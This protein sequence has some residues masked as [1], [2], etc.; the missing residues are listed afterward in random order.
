MTAM[1]GR[2]LEDV[3]HPGVVVGEALEQR[4]QLHPGDAVAPQADEVLLDRQVG[5]DRPEAEQPAATA[6]GDEPVDA[7]DVL[8]GVGDAEQHPRST[9]ASLEHARQRGDLAVAHP[10]QLRN[11]RPQ[12]ALGDR[13]GPGMAVDVDDRRVGS[14]Q[15]WPPSTVMTAPVVKLD[16]SLAR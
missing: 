10:R 7:V 8:R 12:R 2:T 11:P 4:V 16:Q 1:S 13:V 15:G 5:V 6:A 3:P 9:P 14:D